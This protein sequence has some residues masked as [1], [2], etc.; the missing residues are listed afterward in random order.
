MKH[1]VRCSNKFYKE[2][3]VIALGVRDAPRYRSFRYTGGMI[4]RKNKKKDRN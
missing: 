4:E 2:Q 1:H 3:A